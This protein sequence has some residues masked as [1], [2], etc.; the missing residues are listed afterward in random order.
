MPL[1]LPCGGPSIGS[2]EQRQSEELRG[3]GSQAAARGLEQGG[4]L[5]VG[6]GEPG[7]L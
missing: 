4:G 5:A 1:E 2:E 6:M 3:Y 7:A